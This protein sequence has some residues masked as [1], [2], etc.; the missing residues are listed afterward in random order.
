MASWLPAELFQCDLALVAVSVV[1][2]TLPFHWIEM[3]FH[4][5]SSGEIMILRHCSLRDDAPF[6]SYVVLGLRWGLS[7]CLK[8]LYNGHTSPYVVGLLLAPPLGLLRG[9]VRAPLTQK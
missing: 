4:P 6:F 1:L 5:T 2:Q 8:H 9:L 3:L 7:G